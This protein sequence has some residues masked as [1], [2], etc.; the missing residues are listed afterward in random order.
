M[1]KTDDEIKATV[2]NNVTKMSSQIK[3]NADSITSV[4]T[5]LSDAD[6]AKKNYSAIAQLNDDIALRVAKD[7]V[8]NQINIS[9]ESIRI[10][11]NKVHVTGATKFDDDV[12]VGGMI[13]AGSI[14]ADKLSAE[15]IAL[16]NNQGIKGGNVTLDANGMTCTDSSG[17]T[18]QFGQDGMTSKDKNGNKF[19]ILA[20]CM[21]GVAK[22]GKYVKFNN[23]WMEAPVVIV[24]PQN[25]QTNNPAY[26]TSKVRL[27]CYAEDVSVNGFRMRA[28]S[29]IADGSGSFAQYQECGSMNWTIWRDWQSSENKGLPYG[30]RSI[31]FTVKMPSN[32]SR[33]AFRG[34]F[35]MNVGY[36]YD[37]FV[38][39]PN[40]ESQNISIKCDGKETYNG[41]L[42]SNNNDN[43]IHD[44]TGVHGTN[45]YC[46]YV[47]NVFTVA[48]GSDLTC[49]L[50]LSPWTKHDGD[51]SDSL[52][53][54]LIIDSLDVYVD[55]EQI[56]DDDGTGAF[57]VVNSSN[58]LY[59]ITD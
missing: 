52:T 53:V 48:Q 11:G 18:I 2:Q 8:V 54:W 38:G 10:D 57:F 6:K 41:M 49:T 17:T 15:T 22:N 13:A 42:F 20:Q 28:Y 45:E 7:D 32:A 55:G 3:Q 36:K 47:S 33:V 27:H 19:S 26:S 9:K 23:P 40:S 58:G 1:T 12:I 34:R 4:V 5:N 30:K 44:A 24:T 59:T 14:T 31:T 46:S 21:M 16:S 43:K 39:F 50:T 37:N 56:L 29:G 51:G 25:I 35:G